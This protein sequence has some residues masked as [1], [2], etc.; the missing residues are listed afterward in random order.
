MSDAVLV[1]AVLRNR[2]KMVPA[3]SPTPTPIAP[4]ISGDVPTN[5]LRWDIV[6]RCR[7]LVHS[8]HDANCMWSTYYGSRIIIGIGCG[9]AKFLRQVSLRCVTSK[10]LR[11][12][13]GFET[14][15]TRDANVLQWYKSGYKYA[16]ER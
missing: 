9:Q 5:P 3:T 8:A 10:S 13:C 7:L 14:I 11:V 6:R 2:P 15:V 1:V 16:A 4:A 12:F